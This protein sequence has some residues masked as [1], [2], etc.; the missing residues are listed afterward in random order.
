MP[1]AKLWIIPGSHPCVAVETALGMKGIDYSTVDLLPVMHKPVMKVRFGQATVP[2]LELDGE[3]IV[4]S[5]RIMARLDSLVP[6]PRLFPEDPEARTKVQAAEAWGDEVFQPVPRRLIWALLKRAPDAAASYG[7]DEPPLPDFLAKPMTPLVV[8]A[9]RKIHGATDEAVRADLA[10]LPAQLDRIDAW[11]AE[12]VL[13]GESPNAADLQIG[14]SLMLFLTMGD[15][16]PLIEGR[17]CRRL[18][19]DL[20]PYPGHVPAGTVPP[21]WLPQP[22]GAA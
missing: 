18:V 4:G 19:D 11:I 22:A 17:P 10:A 3:R 15:I 6:E 5:R 16:A 12:G 13:G 2:G 7:G 1:N 9:E 20:P 14:S 8:A 21:E